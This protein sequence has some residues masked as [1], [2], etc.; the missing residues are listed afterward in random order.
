MLDH[1]LRWADRGLSIFPCQR[2]LGRPIVTG[3]AK[4]TW[5]TEATGNRSAIVSWWSATPDADIAAVPEMS[6]HFVLIA[7]GERG[8]DSLYALEDEH[9]DLGGEFEY[10][11]AWGDLHLWFKGSALTSHNVIGKGLH[12]I[13]AGNFVYLAPSFAPDPLW[14]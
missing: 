1:A 10:E 5:Y 6:G 14:T 11:N 12:I 8:R 2:F 9:G 7:T 3:T 4:T 13:G